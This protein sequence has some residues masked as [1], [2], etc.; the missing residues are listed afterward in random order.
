MCSVCI[1]SSLSWH[2]S[3]HVLC[4]MLNG[5]FGGGSCELSIFVYLFLC[6][7]VKIIMI[8]QENG[9]QMSS[10][11]WIM[12]IIK[13]CYF[14]TS[15]LTRVLK[16]NIDS[17]YASEISRRRKFNKK[18]LKRMLYN[19][20][21]HILLYRKLSIPETNTCSCET[22]EFDDWNKDI[23]HFCHWICMLGTWYLT[24]LTPG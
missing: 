19:I 3:I 1:L 2:I 7:I 11:V 15:V 18:M 8:R 6:N 24:R 10:M 14:V 4:R 23:F 5:F 12:W 20:E 16:S 21:K 13:S 17:P 9:V 22:Q